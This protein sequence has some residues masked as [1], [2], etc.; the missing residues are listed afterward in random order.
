MCGWAICGLTSFTLEAQLVGP[1]AAWLHG[2][3]YR[4]EAEVP[5]LGRRADLVGA[6]ED[7][8]VAVELKMRDWRE[9]LRQA[10]A[11]QLAADRVFVAMPLAAA[12]AAY[13][14]RWR[15]DTEGV[16]LLAVDDRG[17]VRMPIPACPSR[18]LLPYLRERVIAWPVARTVP[19]A[20]SSRGIGADPIA[21]GGP[22]SY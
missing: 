13:R 6:R 16:G 3:G 22:K 20:G 17:G 2:D 11:Y 12:S 19:V 18:R 21:F 14:A 8:L 7:A 10:M 5:I 15:F 1:V 9:A 4:V